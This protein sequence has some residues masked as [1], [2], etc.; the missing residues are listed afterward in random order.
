MRTLRLCALL[1]LGVAIGYAVSDETTANNDTLENH[2]Q[3][4]AVTLD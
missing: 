4:P 3:Q 1:A 2:S